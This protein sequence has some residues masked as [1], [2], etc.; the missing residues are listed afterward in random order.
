MGEFRTIENEWISY[1]IPTSDWLAGRCG[2]RPEAAGVAQAGRVAWNV[3][4]VNCLIWVRRLQ[5]FW[6]G[7]FEGI[8]SQ[9]LKKWFMSIAN[10]CMRHALTWAFEGNSKHINS[11]F[12]F[13]K[14]VVSQNICKKNEISAAF[15]FDCLCGSISQPSNAVRPQGGGLVR[16]ER[17]VQ[18]QRK[19]YTL[20][21]FPIKTPKK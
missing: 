18:E 19:E 13:C 14:T 4:N 5:F 21:K 10:I 1:R 9:V 12:Q 20:N 6:G 16:I 11:S 15:F 17:C 8:V 3:R 7:L 2:A